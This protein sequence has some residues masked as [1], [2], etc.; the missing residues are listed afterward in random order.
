ML[1]DNAIVVVENIYR[2]QKSGALPKIA[3]ATGTTEVLQAISAATLVHLAV[4]FPIFFFQKRVR[5]FYQDLCYTVCVA[6]LI[7]LLV[8]VILVPV[9]V[10][11][12]A[13]P[14]REVKWLPRLA[15]WHRRQLVRVLRRRAL[16]ITCGLLFFAVSLGLLDR[17]GFETTARVDRGEF[18]LIM[19]TPPATVA[20]VTDRLVHQA[21]QLILGQPEV[22]D[23]STEIRESLAR[24]RV[25]LVPQHQRR[26][27][28]QEL[29][30][31]LR[32]A[33]ASLP[34]TFSH[35]QLERQE[36][37]NYVT[38]EVTGPEQETLISLALEM[39]RRLKVL[40]ELRDV[41]IHL[42]D[43]SPE[44]Q[45]QV[46]YQRA[47]YL[48]LTA[49]DV[50]H[51]IRAALTGPLANRFREP[52]REVELRTRL[53]P[54]D[55]ESLQVLQQLTVPR[56]MD[57]PRRWAQVP[58]CPA[59]RVRRAL[60]ATEIHRFNQVR[61]LEL[62]AE[63]QNLDLYRAAAAILPQ[64]D[65]VSRPAGYEI[66][67]GQS[68]EE[69]QES[70]REVFFALVLGLVLIYMI[71]AALFESFR[72]PLI[73]MCSAPLA[74]VGVAAALWLNGYPISVAVYVGALALAGIVVN[75]AIVLVDHINQ[76]RIRGLGYWR[77]VL[78]GSRDRLRPILITSAT[79]IL[80]LLPMAL[81]RHEGAQ[82]WSPLAWTVIGGLVSSTFLTLFLIPV[83][84]TLIIPKP[85]GRAHPGR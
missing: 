10:T 5:L 77:A 19:Q 85:K 41:V 76:L 22:K 59:I 62:S 55:R 1:V 21:E 42:K 45:I 15:K 6:L 17:L 20:D 65:A 9:M 56:L 58:I 11:R 75:N 53:Q 70:R 37:D 4:F 79:A 23:V 83:V 34:R 71:M 73:V 69:M 67:L 36:G 7:S 82:L 30:E 49:T 24:L 81:E 51:G 39:R 63:T 74:V 46:D 68:F 38:V 64:L 40:P 32:P 35:F 2:C 80:G 57:S 52:G 28:T 25:R 60:G 16:W 8:A 54:Q 31:K 84:Y 13:P 14:R 18:N 78:Q 27:S 33:I 50:A 12:F 26:L 47:A 3:A 43:P 61:G 66:R 48:G 29:V 44:L 72:T